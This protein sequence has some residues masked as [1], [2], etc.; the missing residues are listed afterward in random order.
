[1]FTATMPPI[2][3][4]LARTYLRYKITQITFPYHCLLLLLKDCSKYSNNY[5]TLPNY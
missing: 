4:R 3:E 2:V 5:I 1:M